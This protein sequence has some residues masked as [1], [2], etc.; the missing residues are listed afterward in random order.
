MRAGLRV[1]V[2]GA[3]VA[4]RMACRRRDR[5]RVKQVLHV[6]DARDLAYLALDALDLLEIF[7]LPA[8]DHDPAVGVDADLS[9]G[10]RPV[11]KQLALHLAHETDIVDL[12]W[13]LLT[14]RDRVRGPTTLPAS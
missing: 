9:F 3:W 2:P 10:K 7:D 14:V 8:Q 6:V 5:W 1:P 4:V 11:A 12:W 13:A